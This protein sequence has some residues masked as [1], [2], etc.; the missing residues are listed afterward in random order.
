MHHFGASLEAQLQLIQTHM[1]SQHLYIMTPKGQ[2]SFVYDIRIG[3][4]TASWLV[5]APAFAVGIVEH[6]HGKLRIDP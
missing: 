5:K 4:A 6:I 1:L 2:H 3:H